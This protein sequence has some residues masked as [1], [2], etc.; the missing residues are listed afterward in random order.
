[1]NIA[2]SLVVP[3][4][5]IPSPSDGVW[6]IGPLPIRGYALC[7]ILGIVVAVWV[8]DR[9]WVQRGGRSGSVGDVAV[10]AVPFG[11]VG[12]RIYHVLTDP[13]LYFS[14]GANP[15]TALYIW[16]GGLGIWGAIALGALGAYIG[17]RRNG[18]SFGAYADAL[19]PGIVLAQAIGRVGNWFNQEL[20]GRPTDLPWG[21]EIDAEH[22]GSLPL[23][24]QTSETF[25]PTFLYELLWCV[26]VAALVIWVDRRYR[27][28]HGRAFAV[29]VMAYTV[30][31]GLIETLRVD[32]ANDFFGIRLNVFTSVVV[33]VLAAVYF[34]VV[35]RRR[36]GREEV[37]DFTLAD[38]SDES[39]DADELDADELTESDSADPDDA[40]DDSHGSVGP[41]DNAPDAAAARRSGEQT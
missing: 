21:L 38:E 33:F 36:P 3:L 10:W 25:H 24:M 29:Y 27:L 8:G 32:T 7:I 39:E 15:V 37:V 5:S 17:C 35:G 16:R 6:N 19:A 13:E 11:L 14:E 9:R 30:G 2:S 31:R 28:G 41:P 22:R 20:Y 4:A 1:M 40:G 23:S 34:V 12:G 26:G 18:L